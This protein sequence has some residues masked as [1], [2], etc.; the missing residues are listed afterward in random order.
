V[1]ADQEECRRATD[2]QARVLEYMRE[3][4]RVAFK[5]VAGSGETLLALTRLQEFA[6]EGEQT[7]PVCSNK[8][9][10]GWAGSEVRTPASK[11]S[12][13]SPQRRHSCLNWAYRT[14]GL[15]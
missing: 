14:Q 9:L 1:V 12:N 4:P 8:P 3:V 6:R 7:R 13:R 2:E 10:A 11:H 5:G 15:E